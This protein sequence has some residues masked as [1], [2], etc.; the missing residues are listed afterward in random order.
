MT[1]DAKIQIFAIKR[2]NI[3]GKEIFCSAL[4][5]YYLTIIAK[6]KA[7]RFNKGALS[8][9]IYINPPTNVGTLKDEE[10]VSFVPSAKDVVYMDHPT[11]GGSV[12][13]ERG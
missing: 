3:K 10:I 9:Y 6:Y 5:P 8:D 7:S 2:G 1:P 4:Y 13:F 11:E 12:A